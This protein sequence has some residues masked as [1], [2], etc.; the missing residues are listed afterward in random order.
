MQMLHCINMVPG[1]GGENVFCDGFNVARQM[2]VKHPNEYKI[3]TSVPV[4]YFDEGKD[5]YHDHHHRYARPVIR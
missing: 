1:K 3:L 2:A 4:T 5:T